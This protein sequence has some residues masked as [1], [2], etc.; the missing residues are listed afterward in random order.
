[1][2]ILYITTCWT[3]L[4]SMVFDGEIEAKGMPAFIK[5]LKELSDRGNQ[6]DMYIIHTLKD[7]PNLNITAD[8]MKKIKIVG[9]KYYNHSIIKRVLSIH[10]MNKEVSIILKNTKYDFIYAHGTAPG[11][12]YR[13][14]KKS[15]IP[16]G[17]R[18]YGT[19]LYDEII[20]RG[21][22]KAICRHYI[23]Y[24]I[25]KR[26]KDFLLV[27]D[28]ASN[29]DKVYSL[30]NP[31]EAP[32]QFEFWINGADKMPNDVTD[33]QWIK[34]ENEEFLFYLARISRWKKQDRA[35]RLIKI[36]NDRG[37]KLK[38]YIAGQI[39]EKDYYH[40]LLNL[41]RELGVEKQIVFT[42]AI[43]R[44]MINSFSKRAVAALSFYD[45]G[46]RGNV[47]YE[48][49]AAGAVIIS[50]DDG[51]LDDF[52]VN[53]ENGFLLKNIEDAYEIIEKLQNDEEFSLQVRMNAI[54][55]FNIKLRTWEERVDDEIRLI[56][57]YAL[58]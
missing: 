11:T 13:V 16:Y 42:G 46:N 44:E 51:S 39:F 32:Y 26:E 58:K 31:K 33:N 14:I 43:N 5:P 53:G 10:S 41:A 30:V 8:W 19:F 4:K 55:T 24:L 28:D 27:T 29:G 48:Y 2:K 40:E 49:L 22:K 45:L 23:E 34:K 37:T 52:I 1:M 50:L 21:Y 47:F 15:K 12:L 9:L 7:K 36:L 38:L 35:I 17:H 57:K 18:L 54:N 3:G 20:K 6:I 56:E 25:F